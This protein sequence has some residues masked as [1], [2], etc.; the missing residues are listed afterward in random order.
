MIGYMSTRKNL[1]VVH[2]HT[3]SRWYMFLR[4]V[5]GGYGVD[6]IGLS[7]RSLEGSKSMDCGVGLWM[8][9]VFYFME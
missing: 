5:L 1:L 9:N 7:A 4:G 3:L 6:W 8:R 2:T